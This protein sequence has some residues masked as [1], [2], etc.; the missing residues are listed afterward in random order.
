MILVLLVF[1]EQTGREHLFACF[2]LKFTVARSHG[3]VFRLLE[4]LLYDR[5]WYFYFI[6]LIKH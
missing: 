2:L 6:I 4:I 1:H 5:S 3:V